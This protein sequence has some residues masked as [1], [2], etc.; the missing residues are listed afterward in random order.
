MKFCQRF[1]TSFL[2]CLFFVHVLVP[3]TAF[4][5][6]TKDSV[7]THKSGLQTADF[8]VIGFYAISML[9]IGW[10]FSR[11]VKTTE[12]YMLGGR[13]M[14]SW[15]VG[16][17]L[18]ASLL[19]AISFLAVP[20]E[21]IQHGPMILCFIL[22]YPLL[23]LFVGYVIIPFFMKLKVTSAY[24]ILENKLGLSVRM[25]GSLIFL[26]TR[27]TW[28]ALIIYL[29]ADKIIV[30]VLGWS[31]TTVPYVCAALGILTVVYT[32][33]GGLRAVVFTDIIQTFILFGGAI[34]SIAV[35]TVKMG[36][37]SWWPTEWVS[38]WDVQPLYSID[39]H[40]RVTVLGALIMEFCAWTCAAGS[41][42]IAIQR[43]LS[44]RD[45]RSG[46]HTFVIGIITTALSIILL[47]ILGF[48]LL[49]FFS[50]NQHLIP[51]GMNINTDGDQFFPYFILN[52]LPVGISGL[53]ISALMAASMSSLSS[54]INSACTVIAVDFIDRF[55]KDKDTNERRPILRAKIIALVVGIIA[56]MI[57][58][59]MGK[60]PGNIFEVTNKTNGLFVAPLFG[61]FFMAIFVPFATSF[62]T[63]WGAI[64]GFG[65]AFLIAYWDLLT[66]DT[67]LSFQWIMPGAL[68]VNIIAGPI[69]SLLPTRGKNWRTLLIC[70]LIALAPLIIIIFLIVNS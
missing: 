61:L 60:I 50:S 18:F 19:S 10:Y 40:V 44:T 35:V 4:A 37:L 7:Q 68:I 45:A 57:S 24:E 14:R 51:E 62:G 59:L 23:F 11:K 49:G 30:P 46:R 48:A 33:M 25:T 3:A 9:V 43:Y 31:A 12:D 2:V 1:V 13:K 36:G 22:A 15:T 38:N 65:T 47:A 55:R 66:N 54:G 6:E 20:G 69:L 34:L 41:D 58:L 28:M 32:S 39:P 64:Y 56:I 67:G 17:S 63:I 42:Q 70:N 52:M 5:A 8:I 16:L 27:M 53:I 26:I 21:V 29:S